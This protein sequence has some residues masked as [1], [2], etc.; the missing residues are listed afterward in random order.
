MIINQPAHAFRYGLQVVV[1][2]TEHFEIAQLADAR[3]NAVERE[4]V[5]VQIELAQ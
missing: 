3:G 1:S 2:S 5:V 4:C